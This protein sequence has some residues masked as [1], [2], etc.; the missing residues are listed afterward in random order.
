[1]SSRI[2]QALDRL[3]SAINRLEQSGCDGTPA[4][5][6]VE[7][8]RLNADLEAMRADYNALQLTSLQASGRIDAAINRLRAVL[9]A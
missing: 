5:G 4:E 7:M 9:G 3:D 2:E 6:S 1:M 8:Q